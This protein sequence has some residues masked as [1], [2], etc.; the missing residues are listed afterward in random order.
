MSE[1]QDRLTGARKNLAALTDHLE[2]LTSLRN[3]ATAQVQ[4]LGQGAGV[5]INPDAVLASLDKPY[6]LI[7]T[8]D[9]NTWKVITWRGRKDMPVIGW[10]DWQDD[11][12]IVSTINRAMRFVTDIPEWM[13]ETVGWAPPEF[14][15]ALNP[16]K[17]EVQVLAGD[18]ARFHKRYGT[19]L[20]GATA[21]GFKVK[22]GRAWIEL[23]EKMLG[24][25]IG[26]FAAKPVASGDWNNK[27]ECKFSLRDYQQP[28]IEQFLRDGAE[29][30]ILPSGAGKTFIALYIIAHVVGH[31]VILCDSDVLVGQWRTRLKEY[32][33]HADVEIL[34]FQGAVKRI[35]RLKGT[36][37]LT[38]EGHRLPA[39][40]W[41][42]L[43]FM[44]FTYRA[45]MTATPWRLKRQAMIFALG[46]PPRVIPWKQLIDAGVLNRPRVQVVIVQSDA[47][48]LAW[49][50]RALAERPTANALVYC[51]SIQY[52]KDLARKLDLPFIWGETKNKYQRVMEA[53]QRVVSKAIEASIDI[54]DLTLVIEADVS[55]TG[56]S[57][58]SE[59]QRIGRMLHGKS[60][61]EYFVLL[62]PDEFSRFRGRLLGVEAELG[63]IVEYVDLTGQGIK[64]LTTVPK[65]KS[66]PRART[67]ATV[68]A[69][70]E[71]GAALASTAIHRIILDDEKGFGATR[72]GYMEKAFRILWNTDGTSEE[73]RL[74][75]G[76]GEDPW[77]RYQAALNRL[78][79]VG[80]A[81]KVS[82][83]YY[84]DRARV[85]ALR[86]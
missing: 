81:K 51:D 44:D 49:I 27:A 45:L 76:I 15:A 80:L 40:T 6:V 17:T 1:W 79:K 60:R 59:G 34:T 37:L 48:K 73:L 39:D 61:G 13:I 14:K 2:A 50:K 3:E 77:R 74:R 42:R 29:S 32:A 83:R 38:D 43:A 57:R 30:I 78:V 72:Q 18:R 41:S 31:V 66:A 22:R 84:L 26:P 71:A 46:G 53:Q 47:V 10:I 82:D 64:S 52:G 86:G 8:E 85:N 24:D 23:L 21:D 69:G 68:K 70:D 7:K 11:A 25:G 16:A 63:D 75:T 58:V 33:P 55:R 5:E 9:P 62:T 54:P 28:Y 20:A 4:A 35:N 12:F 19:Y 67:V 65:A 36:F 56:E